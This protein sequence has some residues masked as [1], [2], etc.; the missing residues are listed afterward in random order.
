[1]DPKS[2][3]DLIVASLYKLKESDAGEVPEKLLAYESTQFGSFHIHPPCKCPGSVDDD[4]HRPPLLYSTHVL[5]TSGSCDIK[6]RNKQTQ[7]ICSIKR[8]FHNVR[9]FEQF[10]FMRLFSLRVNSTL[11]NS[12]LVCSMR[13]HGP[14]YFRRV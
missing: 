10:M 3:V 8:C 11:R 7:Q 4:I 5:E 9:N 14:V 1:M 6:H 12:S 2:L 13:L